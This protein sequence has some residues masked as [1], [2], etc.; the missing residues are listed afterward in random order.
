MT[1][2]LDIGQIISGLCLSECM[3]LQRQAHET[4]AR[5]GR[6]GPGLT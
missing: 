6:L 5:C 1:E 3:I 2:L 4:S